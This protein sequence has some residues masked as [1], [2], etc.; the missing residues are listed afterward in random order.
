MAEADQALALT[1]QLAAALPDRRQRRRHPLSLLL[2]QPIFQI[3]C[4]YVDQHDATTLCTDP[5]LKQVRGRLPI[6]GKALASQPTVSRL[7]NGVR[8][9]D[10]YGLAAALGEVYLQQREQ[11]GMPARIVLDLDG[12]DDPTYGQQEGTA[13]HGSYAQYMCHPLLTFDLVRRTNTGQL[14][15]FSARRTTIH[16]GH[17]LKCRLKPQA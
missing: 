15:I 17:T 5:V 16:F 12:T 9:R 10:C 3:A 4:G 8:P 1:E 11:N 7:E 14:T 13:D 6:G 2:A